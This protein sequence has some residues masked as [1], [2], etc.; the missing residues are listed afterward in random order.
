MGKDV[1]ERSKSRSKSAKKVPT[2]KSAN[3]IR[4]PSSGLIV[5]GKRKR[6]PTQ[7]LLESLALL[8]L[9]KRRPTKKVKKNMLV[10]KAIKRMSTMQRTANEGRQFLRD[11]EKI[12]RTARSPAREMISKRDERSRGRSR[13]KNSKM[14]VER[15]NDSKKMRDSKSPG[16]FLSRTRTIMETIATSKHIL[17]GGMIKG[18][19]RSRSKSTKRM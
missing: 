12:K 15:V 18:R 9:T 16:R 2:K 8:K 14:S 6:I 10:K 5:Y 4:R 19:T 17:K 3:S 7:R 13:S 11:A 1:S